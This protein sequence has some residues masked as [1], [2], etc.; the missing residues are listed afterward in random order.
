MGIN[1]FNLQMLGAKAAAVI[2]ANKL[3]A[4]DVPKK[5]QWVLK[6]DFDQ[7]WENF[8]HVP[9]LSKYIDKSRD[10]CMAIGSYVFPIADVN[11][12]MQLSRC[13][14]TYACIA[15]KYKEGQDKTDDM[16]NL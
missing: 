10:Q 12:D 2:F 5:Y 1:N 3:D 16:E 4:A 11:H 14:H 7:E 9:K 15:A 8:Q 6:C 13:E